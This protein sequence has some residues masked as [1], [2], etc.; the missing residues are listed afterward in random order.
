MLV[1][2]LTNDAL[3]ARADALLRSR[4]PS[5]LIS[6][7]AAAEF[8]SALGR[9]MR[10]GEQL[11]AAEARTTFATFD[12]WVARAAQRVEAAPADML[13]AEAFL[14]RPDLTLRTPDALN[15]AIARRMDATLASFD[16]RMAD[17]ARALGLGVIGA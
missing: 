13:T 10:V 8:A 9:R 12:A 5:L 16:D 4:T 17:C 1:A 2:P 14:R 11:T 6:D 3:T 7:F 15:I